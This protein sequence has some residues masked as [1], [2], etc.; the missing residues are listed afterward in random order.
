M[1]KHYNLLEAKEKIKN[2]IM[3]IKKVFGM[4]GL[5]F[6]YEVYMV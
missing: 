2:F 4:I 3:Q 1:S 6:F 5:I